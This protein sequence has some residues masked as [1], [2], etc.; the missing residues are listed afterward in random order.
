MLDQTDLL[1]YKNL[2]QKEEIDLQVLSQLDHNELKLL[3]VA[4]ATYG[5]RHKMITAAKQYITEN[6]LCDASSP[7][8]T[9]PLEVTTK[10]DQYSEHIPEEFWNDWEGMCSAE[11]LNDVSKKTVIDVDKTVTVTTVK[12]KLPQYFKY[13][14]APET[15]KINK[16]L[17]ILESRCSFDETCKYFC[18]D[19]LCAEM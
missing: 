6:A 17:K 4:V 12:K 16:T 18:C 9:K 14:S 8:K 10:E 3:G 11:S 7:K 13:V 5:A 2:F 15:S 1:K 19:C